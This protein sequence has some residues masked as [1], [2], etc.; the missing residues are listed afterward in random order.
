MEV[1]RQSERELNME[2]TS[3]LEEISASPRNDVI[4]LSTK[5]SATQ[6]STT[7]LRDEATS[8]KAHTRRTSNLS[9][10]SDYSI[11]DSPGSSSRPQQAQGQKEADTEAELL[12]ELESIQVSKTPMRPASHLVG[13]MLDLYRRPILNEGD[14]DGLSQV[15]VR[16]RPLL[17]N[18]EAR[19]GEA[20]VECCGEHVSVKAG[21]R[22]SI[23]CKYGP[24]PFDTMLP[25]EDLIRWANGAS[26]ET[27]HAT[28]GRLGGLGSTA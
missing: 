25:S 1:T 15:L 27:N 8:T 11:P 5:R 2:G 16:V 9:V 24:L 17:P 21:A 28:H 4:S 14:W 6:S 12:G 10:A 3:M 22:R 20:V 19:G 23:R 7:F 18:E 26:K 13:A